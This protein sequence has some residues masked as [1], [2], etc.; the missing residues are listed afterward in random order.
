MAG[1]WKR[2]PC[3]YCGAPSTTTHKTGFGYVRF[4]CGPCVPFW[5][6]EEQEPDGDPETLGRG[7]LVLGDPHL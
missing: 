4:A 5:A 3:D 1:K 7:D 2:P 6:R